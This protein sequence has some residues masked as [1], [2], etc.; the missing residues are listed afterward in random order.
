[1]TNTPTKGDKLYIVTESPDSNNSG[2]WLVC[3]QYVT[4]TSWGKT[5]GTAEY[6][7]GS[8]HIRQ[9]LYTS[10]ADLRSGGLRFI[11]ALAGVESFAANRLH[12]SQE[13]IDHFRKHFSSYP[14]V[15]NGLIE[16]PVVRLW[17]TNGNETSEKLF[18]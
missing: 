14:S 3:A 2:R 6:H 16:T 17:V 8:R 5:Q 10:D 7:D 1:M 13:T 12:K 9:R 18:S 4:I 11:A 15:I